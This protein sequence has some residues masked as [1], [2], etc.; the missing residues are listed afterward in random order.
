MTIPTTKL[1]IGGE[2][3]EAG[4]ES[5][6]DLNPLDDSEIAMV[7][8]ATEEDVDRALDNAD[9]AFRDYRRSTPSERERWLCRAAELLDAA[10]DDFVKLLI[11]EVGS[12]LLKAQREISTAV[13]VLRSAGAATRFLAGKTMPTNVPG[14]WSMSLRQ[15]LGVVVGMTPFNVP[16]IKNVK[17]SA[18][19][20][21][22][23]N[24]VLLLPSPHAPMV[25]CRLAELYAAAGFPPGAFNVITGFGESI[26]DRLISDSRVRM[27]CFTGSTRVGRHLAELCGRHG[28]RCK[29]EMGGKN[30]LIILE[31]AN[32]DQA[33]QAAVL[34]SFL[35]QG[36]ICMASSRIYVERT[37]MDSFLERFTAAAK[38]LQMGDL[39]NART[40]IGPI[41]HAKQRERIRHHVED[42]LSKGARI[43]CGGQW[44]GNRLQPT[45]LVDVDASMVIEGEETFGPIT[46]VYPIESPEE[47]IER[48]NDSP[49]GLTASVY[50][51]NLSQAMRFA[52]ELQVGMVH[53]NAPSIQEEPHAP[54][55]GIGDSGHGRESTD[56]DLEDMTEW[57][58]VTFQRDV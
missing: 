28:K 10:S 49:F 44:E 26:G 48:A 34:G 21:A 19:P 20:L 18:M 39:G 50:T 7:A 41:I 33:I 51:E 2:W 32:L 45:I 13:G 53:I 58:W 4:G 8:C 35:Y 36:Q 54:F 40:M 27:V 56:P 9:Q 57:K 1:W 42:A 30:P 43:L 31:D 46:T 52:E 22:T 55:G 24:T 38:Q 29:L 12:P 47:A 5:F 11:D 25:A 3:A 37:R 23:G 15:P 16:L 6:A 14:R 17:H